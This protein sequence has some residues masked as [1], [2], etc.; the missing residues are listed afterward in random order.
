M[1]TAFHSV[2]CTFVTCLFNKYS[3]ILKKLVI[4]LNLS[5][6]ALAIVHFPS[7]LVH[8]L[9]KTALFQASVT[10]IF[11]KPPIWRGMNGGF[12]TKRAEIVCFHCDVSSCKLDLARR[13]VRY[14][15]AACGYFGKLMHKIRPLKFCSL[16]SIQHQWQYSA[17]VVTVSE[18]QLNRRLHKTG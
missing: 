7:A 11:P 4:C 9:T 3:K 6:F 17:V 15:K 5:N 10:N 16:T 14:D 18:Q 13:G 2:A 1:P 12:Q 8:S